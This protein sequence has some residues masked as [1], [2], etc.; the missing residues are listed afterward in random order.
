MTEDQIQRTIKAIDKWLKI[1]KEKKTM[2]EVLIAGGPSDGRI[3]GEFRD[4]ADA[5]DMIAGYMSREHHPEEEITIR[6]MDE[7]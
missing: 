1:R 4:I 6:R 3:L 2:Y 5:Y 7:I